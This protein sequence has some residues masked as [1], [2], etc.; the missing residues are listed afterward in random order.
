MT[1][2]LVSAFMV[3]S[4]GCQ[5][6]GTGT[7]NPLQNSAGTN[8]AP[9]ENLVA[10]ICRKLTVCH[11]GLAP[12]VCYS[13]VFG[14]SGLPAEFGI[15]SGYDT[16]NDV[17]EAEVAKTLSSDVA[18]ANACVTT[19]D[20]LSCSAPE[21]LNA[22]QPSAADPWADLGLMIPSVCEQVYAP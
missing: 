17:H 15:A 22:Y 3:L 8:S 12:G 14:K 10:A 11:A 13:N 19:I 6:A 5:S 9:S 20:Q 18:A 21:V 2:F 7:G 1:R 16:L 4:I